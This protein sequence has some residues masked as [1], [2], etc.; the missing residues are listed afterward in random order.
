MLKLL[1]TVFI[2]FASLQ[3]GLA[4]SRKLHARVQCLDRLDS[5]LVQ[6]LGEIRFGLRPLPEIFE[7]LGNQPDGEGFA[8]AA[9]EINLRDGRS[10]KE[11]FFF[12]I[13]NS[14]PL[15][16]NE[17]KLVLLSLGEGLGAC[18]NATQCRLIES[19]IEELAVKRRAAQEF[20]MK[21]GRLY[22]GLG[23]TGGLFLILLL[24]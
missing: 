2:L 17:D 1:G 22:Q 7:K 3:L 9:K 8:L 15:L 13:E 14:Y 11:C 6:F 16:T 21:N 23:I 10:A 24:I 19:V 20:A 4:K 18:D 5:L 12:A